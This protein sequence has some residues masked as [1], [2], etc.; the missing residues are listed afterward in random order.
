MATAAMPTVTATVKAAAAGLTKSWSALWYSCL[1]R[2]IWLL[3][4]PQVVHAIWLRDTDR[5][6]S[7]FS[8]RAV[9][10]RGVTNWKF[11]YSYEVYVQYQISL[12]Q[13][14]CASVGCTKDW[15]SSAQETHEDVCIDRSLSLARSHDNS[16][17]I[18]RD[19]FVPE[20]RRES[21]GTV[22]GPCRS[23]VSIFLVYTARLEGLHDQGIITCRSVT[24]EPQHCG[25][26]WNQLK[27]KRC[28]KLVKFSTSVLAMQNH[29]PSIT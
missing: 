1:L 24:L 9:K 7:S 10:R 21:N 4:D 19:C 12:G 16:W 22:H 15:R 13:H 6:S 17:L 8:V 25:R 5:S 20:K 29:V 27:T 3:W 11:E 2:C 14:R 26:N 18:H 23:N 28:T